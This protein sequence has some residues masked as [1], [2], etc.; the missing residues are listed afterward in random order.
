MSSATRLI[1]S[2][3]ERFPMVVP[4]PG[5]TSSSGSP[6]SSPV[7]SFPAWGVVKISD[8]V[9]GTGR[10]CPLCPGLIQSPSQASL[11]GLSAWAEVGGIASSL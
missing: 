1:V 6:R 4:S 7:C 9:T 5:R 10:F 3:A 8:L 11:R 2:R